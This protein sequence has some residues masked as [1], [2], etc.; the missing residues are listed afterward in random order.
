MVNDGATPLS[1]RKPVT[2]RLTSGALLSIEPAPLCGMISLRGV[3]T[4]DRFRKAVRRVLGVNLSNQ[5]MT[6]SVEGSVKSF[7]LGPDV[8][9]IVT[10]REHVDAYVDSLKQNLIGQHVSVVDVSHAR[11]IV[12]ATGERTAD[13]LMKGGTIDFHPVAFTCGKVVQASFIDIPCIYHKVA[14][15]PDTFDLYV[16]SSY[17]E[18]AWDWLA[19]A[20]TKMW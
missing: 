15:S 5:P 1:L 2:K 6:C 19:D 10:L 13:L 4:K 3:F 7:W 20:L 8:W 12:R 9:L 16:P 18:F 17:C 11:G 14:N